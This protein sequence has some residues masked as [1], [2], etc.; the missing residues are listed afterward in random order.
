M[1]EICFAEWHVRIV[2]GTHMLVTNERIL[3]VR[4]IQAMQQILATENNDK[5]N[6][7]LHV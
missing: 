2:E 7:T 5:K 4:F 3:S 6:Y 1:M